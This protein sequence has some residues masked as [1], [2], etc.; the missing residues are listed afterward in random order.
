MLTATLKNQEKTQIAT[1]IYA[2]ITSFLNMAYIL[3]LAPFMLHGIGM[4]TDG[5]STSVCISAGLGSILIGMVTNLP[6][7]IAPSVSLLIFFSQD[8]IIVN[9]FTWQ[10]SLGITALAHLCLL[11]ASYYNLLSWILKN[12][13]P[14]LKV[15]ISCGIAL[16]ITGVAINISNLANLQHTTLNLHLPQITIFIS[17]LFLIHMLRPR[18]KSSY[19]ILTIAALSI[20]NLFFH[21]HSATLHFVEAPHHINH[22]L[23]HWEWPTVHQLP[24]ALS[25]IFAIFC[26]NLIDNSL[27]IYTLY[28]PLCVQHSPEKKQSLQNRSLYSVGVSNIAASFLGC[29][30]VNVHFESATGIHCGGKTG[31]AA[32]TTGL[33]F[34]FCLFFTPVIHLIPHSAIGACLTY[35]T[36]SIACKQLRQLPLH[37]KDKA[38]ALITI[39]SIP[40]LH[41]IP[42]GMSLGLYS[43]ALCSWSNITAKQRL[44]LCI[45]LVF[46]TGYN[47]ILAS[48]A[49][50]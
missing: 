27:C 37:L 12:L 50:G 3:L 43:Y 4:P 38:P 24:K 34:L 22:L 40:L 14:S 46:F 1:D 48:A 31:L 49:I 20:V 33:C 9:H 11:I 10:Q 6:F 2:G 36:L 7:A 44:P 28:Q 23:G 35:T 39:L 5:I 42:T 45:M 26:I 19:F 29:T 41:S 17:G 18:F 25:V 30:P 32:I 16:M 8:M 15:G 21:G 13:P 47:S